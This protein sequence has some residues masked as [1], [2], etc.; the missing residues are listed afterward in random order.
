ML[1]EALRRAVKLLSRDLVRKAPELNERVVNKVVRRVQKSTGLQL[2]YDSSVPLAEAYSYC[3]HR[4]F[5]RVDLATSNGGKLSTFIKADKLSFKRY[6]IAKR[7]SSRALPVPDFYDSF[8][9]GGHKYGIWSYQAG[10]CYKNYKQFSDTQLVELASALALLNVG[11]A[12]LCKGLALP[13]GSLWA[14]PIAA[15]V[16]ACLPVNEKLRSCFSILEDFKKFEPVM[17]R[18]LNNGSYGYLNH[19]DCK[20][21]NVLLLRNGGVSITDWDS[22]SFGPLGVSLR[23][24]ANAEFKRRKLVVNAYVKSLS[25]LGVDLSANAADQMLCLQ[26]VFWSL[27]TG[28]HL[29]DS[30]RIYR[31]LYLFSR[32]FESI[33]GTL[34]LKGVGP[35]GSLAAA[36]V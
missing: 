24:F 21:S 4:R 13:V 31:G 12:A 15:D 22:A 29:N 8:F 2:R 20:A 19:N 17:L 34:W 7:L 11:G 23:C 3:P 35:V 25:E 33:E 18:I 1:Q 26:Q 10:E 36:S 32:L 28:V 30:E 6:R 16:A 27:A 5:W 14:R 9:M